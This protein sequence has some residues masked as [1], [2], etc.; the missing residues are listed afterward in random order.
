M[1]KY[2]SFRLPIKYMIIPCTPK[3]FLK[4]FTFFSSSIRMSGKNVN[5]GD[6]KNQKNDSYKNK[7]VIKIDDIDVKIL[8]SKEEPYGSKNHLNTLLDTM[9]MMLLDHYA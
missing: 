9:I 2:C 3:L 4:K 6:K 8:A 5:F 7:I 1:L